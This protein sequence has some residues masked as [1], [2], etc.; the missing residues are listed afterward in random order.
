MPQEGASNLSRNLML[1]AIP[2]LLAAVL[3]GTRPFWWPTSA[4]PAAPYMSE[5]EINTNRQGGDIVNIDKPE[6]NTAG[7]CSVLC[8]QNVQCMAMTFVSHPTGGGICW[9]KDSLPSPSHRP[10]MTSAAKVLPQRR[11]Q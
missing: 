9:L 5:L 4:I 6:V 10:G 11:R 8:L 1:A 3:A 2:V 7:D